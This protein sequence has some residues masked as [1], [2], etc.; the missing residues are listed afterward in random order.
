M[1]GGDILLLAAGDVAPDRDDP[2]E[3]FALA[4]ASRMTTE[5]TLMKAKASA[6]SAM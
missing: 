3:C 2:A 6:E 1:A 4:A 5:P